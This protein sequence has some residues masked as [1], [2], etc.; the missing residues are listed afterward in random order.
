MPI[1][2][3]TDNNSDV[4]M[5]SA[6]APTC[7]QRLTIPNRKVVKLA[8]LL[9]KVGSPTGDVTFTIRKVSDK[10]LIVSKLWGQAEDLPTDLTW[11]E[12]EFDTPTLIDEVVR[13]LIEVVNYNSSNYV[14]PR[15]QTSDVKANECWTRGSVASPADYTDWDFVY[16]YTYGLPPD[17]TAYNT[18]VGSPTSWMW[19]KCGYG[20]AEKCPVGS[21]PNWAWQAPTSGGPSKTPQGG[22][23]SFIW[24]SE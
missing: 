4:V 20:G 15:L 23:L 5:Y 19:K 1:E 8:F 10:S 14:S 17:E 11:E 24:G 2:E 9:K 12:V 21:V 7:G 3:Q 13:I 22:S 18:K 16:R 6:N